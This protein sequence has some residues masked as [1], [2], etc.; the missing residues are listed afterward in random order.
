MM[1]S[2]PDAFKACIKNTKQKIRTTFLQ[3]IIKQHLIDETPEIHSEE[4]FLDEISIN[5]VVDIEIE[6]I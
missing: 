6:E 1:V 5:D 2:M 3:N 4:E